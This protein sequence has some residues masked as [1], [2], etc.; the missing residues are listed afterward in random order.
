MS[1]LCWV[2]FQC[3]LDLLF[4][5][6]SEFEFLPRV[7]ASRRRVIILVH[8]GLG[9]A[10]GCLS[11][12]L[13]PEHVWRAPIVQALNLALM[14][15]IAG[16]GLKWLSGYRIREDQDRRDESSPF[17]NGAAFAFAALL[18]RLMFAM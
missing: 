11:L 1:E 6:D 8:V 12:R 13:L 7:F 16:L 3:A 9:A 14:P 4:V 15:M 17:D 18:V 10:F 2:I 5:F